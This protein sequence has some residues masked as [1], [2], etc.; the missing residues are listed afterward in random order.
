MSEAPDANLK[1]SDAPDGSFK[2]SDVIDALVRPAEVPVRGLRVLSL[3][4]SV[5]ATV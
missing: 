4:N 1:K 2:K 5:A 3:G